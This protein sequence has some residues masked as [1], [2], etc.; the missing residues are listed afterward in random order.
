M[1]EGENLNILGLYWKHLTTIQ[2]SCLLNSQE[3]F[4]M[5]IIW[6]RWKGDVIKFKSDTIIVVK[7]S[8]PVEWVNL[9]WDENMVT[10][11][12]GNIVIKDHGGTPPTSTLL[13][14]G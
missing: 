9:T 8:T 12:N 2:D 5:G 10:T 14:M 6:K 3:L 1:M 7:N 13:V 11:I 4:C